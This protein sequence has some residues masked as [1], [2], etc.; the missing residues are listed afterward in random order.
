MMHI[1]LATIGVVYSVSMILLL[2]TIGIVSFESPSIAM[3]SRAGHGRRLADPA[4]TL[5]VK[6]RSQLWN[7]SISESPAS[8]SRVSAS[9][10]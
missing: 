8:R 9:A 6:Q 10:A 3:K 7:T 4:H 1:K 5:R 2:T